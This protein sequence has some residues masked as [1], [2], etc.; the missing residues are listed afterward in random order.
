MMTPPTRRL[1]QLSAAIEA[2]AL[3][4]T[5]NGREVLSGVSFQIGAGEV[6]GVLGPNGAGKTSTI[7]VLNGLLLP[8]R[9][10]A[11][12]LGFD[13]VTDGQR[14]RSLTGV[15]TEAPSLY[16]RLSAREN[17]AFFGQLY[18]LAGAALH[19]AI[20]NAFAAVGLQ[21]A[22]DLPAG[23]FSRGMKQRLAI[24]R[25]IL[26]DPSVLFLDEPTAGLDPIAAAQIARL[27]ASFRERGRTIFLCT[28]HL[29]EAERICDRFVLFSRG[30][31]LDSGTR[32][33]LIRRHGGSPGARLEF[34]GPVPSMPDVPGVAITAQSE[35]RLDVSLE[36]P[37]C[38]PDLVTAAVRA[39]GRIRRVEPLEPT[40]DALYQTILAGAE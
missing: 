38:L 2:D 32:E 31:V 23:G 24:A 17:L 8:D 25:A 1:C 28:H 15:L 22:A 9:G 4:L 26:H 27:I 19:L 3:H 33:A 10:Q 29:G 39:G 21:E 36:A 37:A 40:L 14:I 11:R 13:P 18:G 20:A 12:V 5:L 7:R 6:C 30:R 35:R 34:D 16:D